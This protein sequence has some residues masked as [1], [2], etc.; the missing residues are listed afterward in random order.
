MDINKV[1]DLNELKAF[2][3]DTLQA[4]EAQQNNLRILQARIAELEQD[5]SKKK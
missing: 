1:T 4:L 3:Y 5:Q 2:A